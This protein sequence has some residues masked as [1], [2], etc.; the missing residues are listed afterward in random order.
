[1]TNNTHLIITDADRYILTT[2]FDFAAMTD[3]DAR[4]L[5]TA[6]LITL[7]ERAAHDA[8]LIAALDYSDDDTDYM[9]A[10]ARTLAALTSA[11]LNDLTPAESLR[12]L[13]SDDDFCAD[14]ITADIALAIDLDFDYS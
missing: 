14:L 5:M 9:P 10:R 13:L 3:D 2:P 6:S 4:S 7:T 8:R 1:M 12:F 11:L